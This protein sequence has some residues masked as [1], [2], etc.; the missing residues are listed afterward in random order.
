MESS[1]CFFH[2]CFCILP[3]EFVLSVLLLCWL[4][5]TARLLTV[6]CTENVQFVFI[7][8]ASSKS[9]SVFHLSLLPFVRPSSRWDFVVC[10]N[11]CNTITT[12]WLSGATD[13]VE[14]ALQEP[15]HRET[16]GQYSCSLLQPESKCDRTSECVFAR[17]CVCACVVERI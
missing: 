15:H 12:I 2:L 4:T 9:L 17:V 11:R 6:T 7:K 14:R 1:K 16:D 13:N 8:C 5:I 3:C 10:A